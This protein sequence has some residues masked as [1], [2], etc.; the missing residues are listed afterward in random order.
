MLWIETEVE[1]TPGAAAAICEAMR[2]VAMADGN[3]DQREMA[4]IETM[5]KSLPKAA[6]PADLRSI[7]TPD[8]RDAFMKSAIMIALA[9]GEISETERNVINQLGKRIG[10]DGM[11]V[12]KRIIDVKRYFIDVMSRV[13]IFR[14]AV[15]EVGRGMGMDEDQVEKVGEALPVPDDMFDDEEDEEGPE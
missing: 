8:L 12:A 13:I 10:E 3:F 15:L 14:E 11:D 5:K 1:I 6:F 9:D 4:L 7:N 2:A